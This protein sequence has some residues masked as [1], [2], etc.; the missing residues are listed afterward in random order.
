MTSSTASYLSYKDLEV[1]T[2]HCDDGG[3][4]TLWRRST[5]LQVDFDNRSWESSLS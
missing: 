3:R 2:Y 4:A 5:V 1:A